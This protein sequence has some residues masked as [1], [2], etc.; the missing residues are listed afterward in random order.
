MVE[1]LNVVPT[2]TLFNFLLVLLPSRTLNYDFSYLRFPLFKHPCLPSMERIFGG[3]H[4][5]HIISPSKSRQIYHLAHTPPEY[6]TPEQ[7]M[8]AGK[9]RTQWLR[10]EQKR[11]A[12]GGSPQVLDRIWPVGP[13]WPNGDVLVGGEK[14]RREFRNHVGRA[15]FLDQAV[16]LWSRYRWRRAVVLYALSLSFSF[17]FSQTE[18]PKQR[19]GDIQNQQPSSV[20][21]T[22]RSIQ[23]ISANNSQDNHFFFSSSSSSPSTSL[24]LQFHCLTSL[25]H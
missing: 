21:T 25:S 19:T 5:Y 14:A 17:S 15:R 10:E 2:P 18:K 8:Q 24:Q 22:T 11:A 23:G 4:D 16:S 12:R 6:W 13:Y 7:R 20:A 3:H 1:P 9:W